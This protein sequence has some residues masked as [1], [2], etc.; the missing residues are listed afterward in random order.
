MNENKNE[1]YVD[2]NMT[3]LEV[4]SIKKLDEIHNEGWEVCYIK[5]YVGIK[6]YSPNFDGW[7]APTFSPQ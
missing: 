5:T 6:K 7:E 2:V 4:K 1:K 3:I